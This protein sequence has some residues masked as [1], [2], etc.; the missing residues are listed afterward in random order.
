MKE[1]HS[2]HRMK[3]LSADH[4][5]TYLIHGRSGRVSY[6]LAVVEDR[7]FQWYWR[8]VYFSGAGGSYIL[9]VLE[10]RTFQ[11]R[12]RSVF[13]A[14]LENVHFSGDGGSYILSGAGGS[15]ILAVME[16]R[17]FQ[18]CWEIVHFSSNERA[19]ILAVLED[20]TFYWC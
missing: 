17:T 6:I 10:D 14:V 2:C 15:Y 4:I 5:S 1:Q 11:L 7:T 9:A 16:E 13:V 12:R 20:R 8:I 3:P 18:R 19:Y